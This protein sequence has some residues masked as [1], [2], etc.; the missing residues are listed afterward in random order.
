MIPPFKLFLLLALIFVFILGKVE[1]IFV[2]HDS[3]FVC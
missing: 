2:R 3:I 1:L